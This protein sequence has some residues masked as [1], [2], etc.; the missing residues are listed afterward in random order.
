MT[1]EKF[2]AAYY[3]DRTE[4]DPLAGRPG[5]WQKRGK[6]AEALHCA[7]ALCDPDHP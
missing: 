7:L 6:P 5:I 3:A 1:V 2:A 4:N